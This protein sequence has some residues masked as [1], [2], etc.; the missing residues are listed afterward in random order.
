MD[1]IQNCQ[2]Y[3][4][5]KLPSIMFGLN[6]LTDLKKMLIGPIHVVF[7]ATFDSLHSLVCILFC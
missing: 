3:F 1:I 2:Q 4:S 7:F 5:V 6:V